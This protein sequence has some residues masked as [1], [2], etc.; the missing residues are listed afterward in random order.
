[1]AGR[2]GFH[3]A[4]YW[5]GWALALLAL[6]QGD[7]RA[8]AA[9]EPLLP[10]FEERGLP[11]PIVGFSCPTRSKRSSPWATCSGRNVC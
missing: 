10:M 5:A 8:G 3:I 2:V 4:L 9:L 6:S 7:A 1:L 11:E